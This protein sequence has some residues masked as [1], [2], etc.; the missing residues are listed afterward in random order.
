LFIYL[1]IPSARV[2]RSNPIFRTLAGRAIPA[3]RA[4]SALG[5]LWNIDQERDG[6]MVP[7]VI[8]KE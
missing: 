6:Q 7:G 4:D 5:R 2:A 8:C 1:A 3:A